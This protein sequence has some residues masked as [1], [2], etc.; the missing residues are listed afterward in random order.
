MNFIIQ[1]VEKRDS[2]KHK[3]N[4]ARSPRTA[5]LILNLA[6]LYKTPENPDLLYFKMPHYGELW[7]Q[8]SDSVI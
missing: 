8:E 5:A 7:Q 1:V 4:T 3:K 2:Y 6:K